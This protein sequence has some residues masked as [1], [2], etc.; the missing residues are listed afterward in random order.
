MRTG[1]HPIVLAVACLSLAASVLGAEPL[2]YPWLGTKKVTANI[3]NSITPPKGYHRTKVAKGSFADWLRRLPLK[4][5]GAPV[6]LH[7]GRRKA[8]QRAHFRVVEIDTGRRNL[9]Q[10]ADIVIRL[11][12]EYLF[13]RQL[14]PAIHFNFTSGDEASFT[15]WAAGYRPLV[16]GNKVRWAKTAKPDSSYENFRK[17]LST[18]FLYA[19]T[20]SL[21]KE[22][23]ARKSVQD[24]AIGDVFI[25]GGSPGHA[26][27]V[28]DLAVDRRSGHK[29]FL[30]AQSYMPAQDF[31][32]LR[33][34]ND[35]DR[36]PWY[37]LDF[38]ATLRTPE[39]TFR[40]SELMCFGAEHE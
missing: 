26:A 25:R 36:S 14:H 21:S 30:I 6:L 17:Y 33:N 31:H 12:A 28:V 9:Q 8:N 2:G 4:E 39:W 35:P 1:S 18:V 13:L 7:T 27:I 19:G 32:I 15:R 16:R 23:V 37:R 38:G 34:P 5:A 20:L 3:A 24:M 10:C 29:V 40:K 11:K 22:L